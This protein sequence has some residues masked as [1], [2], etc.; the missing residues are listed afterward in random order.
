MTLDGSSTETTSS[1]IGYGTRDN[2]RVALKVAKRRGD[3]WLAGSIT[4]AFDGRG[5]VR[6]LELDAGV[7]L[8][9][10]A[11]PGTPLADVAT[12]DD[13]RATT[14]LAG[15][16]RAFS[17]HAA[18]PGT[19]TIEEWCHGFDRYRASGDQQISPSLVA[20]AAA[21]NQELCA[22]QTN[23]RL[24]HGDLQHSNVL[25]DE[26]RGWIAIDPK[27]VVGEPEAEVGPFLRN[28]THA[29]ELFNDQRIVEHRLRL[30]CTTA[31]LR[32]ARAVR[33]AFSLAVL[34]AI[35]AVEDDGVVHDDNPA[36]ILAAALR[37]S[38]ASAGS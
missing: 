12:R 19:P 11:T 16:M 18:P 24:L 17:P 29:V 25:F 33:W 37:P 7:V 31:G 20:E 30:L 32:Y 4:R 6:V 35:W 22:S 14:I 21:L 38:I 26:D 23:R 27:G 5:V 8:L 9:E 36:L 34:S 28:P 1:V 15:I 2:R 3:E 10:R 13:D